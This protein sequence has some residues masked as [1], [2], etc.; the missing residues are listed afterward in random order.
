M[1]EILKTKVILIGSIL[2]ESQ[3]EYMND[4]ILD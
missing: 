2:R 1:E 4:K 3:I